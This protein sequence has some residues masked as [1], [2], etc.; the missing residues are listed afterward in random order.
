VAPVSLSSSFA[1]DCV[2]AGSV[3]AHDEHNEVGGLACGLEPP[4]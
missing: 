1:G 3:L 2:P 4:V